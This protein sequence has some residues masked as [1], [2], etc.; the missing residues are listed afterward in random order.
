[1][2][3]AALVMTQAN[4]GFF[5]ASLKQ[6]MGGDDTWPFPNSSCT[7]PMGRGPN[8]AAAFWARRAGLLVALQPLLRVEGRHAAEAR[9]GHRLPIPEVVDVTAHKDAV[10]G[11]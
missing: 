8:R 10:N 7:T 1:M 5:V 11:C 6:T 2:R 4:A 3:N 9:G